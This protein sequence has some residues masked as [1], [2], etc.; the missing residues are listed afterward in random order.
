VIHLRLHDR[1]FVGDAGSSRHRP[2]AEVAWR[3]DGPDTPVTVYTDLCLDAAGHAPPGTTRV[4]WV[5]EPAEI[6]PEPY[7]RIARRHDDFDLVLTHHA[8][9]LAIGGAK[10]ALYPNGMTWIDAEDWREHAKTRDVSIV[11]SAQ[12]R[13]SGHRLRHDLVARAG[14]ALDVW[15]KGYRPVARKVTALGPYRFSVAIENSRPEGSYFTEK[16][17]DCFA[18]HTIPVYWGC[19]SIGRYFDTRGMVLAPTLDALEDAARMCA[20]GGA[21]LYASMRDAVRRNHEL[22]K[23][24]AVAE[25]WIVREVLRPRGLG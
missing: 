7:D 17:L 22:A 10:A 6:N 20:R 21:R 16:L 24:Y 2:P 18:T 25:D 13:T 8:S 14:D 19:P 11:A 5:L 1:N 9:L 4:A 3:R 12:R 23:R 15:G